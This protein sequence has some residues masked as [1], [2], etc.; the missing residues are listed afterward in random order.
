MQ[1]RAGCFALF[2]TP[3]ACVAEGR[4]TGFRGVAYSGGVVPNYGWAGDM[5]IDLASLNAPTEVAILRN[6]DSNQIVGRAKVSC[7]GN[8][9]TIEDGTFSTVTDA[10]REVSGLMGEGQPWALSVGV[11]AKAQFFEPRRKVQCNGQEMDV[12]CLLENAR[13]LE[14]SFVP[15]GAD[16]NAYAAQMSARMG[17]TP[18]TTTDDASMND[19][20]TARA[21]IIELESQV[22][23]LTAARDAAQTQLSAIAARARTDAVVALFGADA[24]PTD[25]QRAAYLAMTEAQWSAVEA[26]VKAA[27]PAADSSLFRQSA[28]AGRDP[29]AVQAVTPKATAAL[30]PVDPERE[31]LHAQAIAYQLAHKVSFIAAARAVGA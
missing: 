29:D 22:A 7:D 25:E 14:V 12:D 6:H 10:G 1:S 31:Q 3:E 30:L 28:T 9:L 8:T 26:A 19:L 20:E 27:R 17:L 11:N 4:V 18:P 16:P 21:N 23:T 24:K 2:A 15:A 5:A 13:L